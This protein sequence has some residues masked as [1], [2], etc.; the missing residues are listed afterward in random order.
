M[1]TC[2]YHP[3]DDVRVLEEDEAEKLLAS[4]MWFDSP[5]KAQEYRANVEKDLKQTKLK[6]DKNKLTE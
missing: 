2:I 1:L 4:G 6:A 5:L 3:I